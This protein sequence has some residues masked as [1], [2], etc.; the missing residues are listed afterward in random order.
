MR[1]NEPLDLLVAAPPTGALRSSLARRLPRSL[2]GRPPLR[3]AE[4]RRDCATPRPALAKMA[5]AYDAYLYMIPWYYTITHY[6]VLLSWLMLYCIAIY[7]IRMYFF[8]TLLSSTVSY[9]IILSY[10]VSYC[11]ILYY[12]VLYYQIAPSAGVPHK[13]PHEVHNG[14]PQHR[15]PIRSTRAAP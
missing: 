15:C 12:L 4:R 8:S 9:C 14:V 13:V 7:C 2:A 10:I 1:A 6:Y 3:H 11:I 5:A